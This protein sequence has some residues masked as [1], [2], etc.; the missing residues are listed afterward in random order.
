MTKEEAKIQVARLVEKYKKSEKAGLLKG[1]TEEETKK[2][3]ILPLFE[4][5]GW[6]VYDKQEVSAEEHI[7][8]SGQV[9]YGFYLN[10]RPA[11]YLEA[12]KI[13][14]DLNRPEFANQAVRYSWNKNVPWAILAD[15]EG[16]KVLNAQV[17]ERSLSDKVF[18]DISCDKYLD[19]FDQLWLLSK[20][21]F[22]AGK[23][24]EEAEKWGKKLKRIPVNDLLYKDL[25]KCRS[26]LTTAFH[27]WNKNL[28]A[29]LLYDGVQKVLDRIIFIRVLEDRG[30]EPSTLI[31]MIRQWR[32]KPTKESLYE[33]VSN[34]LQEF[35]DRYNS[36]IFSKH[37]S[38][39]W[40]EHSDAVKEVI[41]I[42]Y[43]REGY[44][45][46]DFKA[47]PADVLGNVYEQ[48]L[49]Y[50]LE[51][52]KKRRLFGTDIEVHKDSEKRK[53]HGIY[54]TPSYIVDYIVK[55][56][57]GPVLDRCTSI[58]DL[59]KIKVLDPACGSGSFLVRAFNLIK[60]KYVLDF[61]KNDDFSLKYMILLNNIYGVDL[62]EQAIEIARLNL[63]IN[64]VDSKRKLPS[65]DQNIKV[66]NSLLQGRDE[67]LIKNLGKNYLDKR[68]F[69]WKAEFPEVFRQGGF[70]VIIGNPPYIGEKGH[71]E[72][73]ID[74]RAGELAEF[75]KGKMD[76]FYFFFHLALNI[77]K[78]SGVIG[79]ITTNYY[80]TATGGNMLRQDMKSRS[81]V[82]QIINLGELKIFESALGQHNIITILQ[83]GHDED[84][85]A[86]VCVTTKEGIANESVLHNII[87]GKDQESSCSEIAQKDLYDGEDNY[88]R[89]GGNAKGSNDPTQKILEKMQKETASLGSIC[90]VNQGIVTGADKV[91]RKHL[92]KYTIEAELGQGIY[93][94]SDGEVNNLKLNK[95][96]KEILKPWYKNSDVHRWKTNS[97]TTE[98]LILADKRLLNLEGNTAKN[99][100]GKFKKI[101][102]DST[103]N[104]PYIHRPRD[105][106][107]D[108][109]KIVVPQRS[110]RNT[111]GY[112]EIPWYAASDVYFITQQDK[113]V[114]LKY[115]LALLNSK[116]YYFWLYHRGKRKGKMLEFVQTPLSE[117]PIQKISEN[118][119]NRFI[120]SA[121]R[122][123]DIVNQDNYLGSPEKQRKVQEYE[124]KI[125]E[126]VY[127]LYGLTQEEINI[128]EEA[129]A[130]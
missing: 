41:N 53:E 61:G 44:Y 62:D 78:E 45:E 93:V 23:L 14:V 94:L 111:F 82:R 122:I 92:S 16:I 5:L 77:A 27:A 113:S 76:I 64:A 80:L 42:L 59:Q 86:K 121:D 73:F 15:F 8:S 98:R 67:D 116:L 38:D 31:P 52:S 57:L 20:E 128:V 75:Y 85:Q 96:E 25:N 74:I 46:Y 3:F 125:D 1:Y 70:D 81:I 99:Y 90:N 114:S 55:S 37:H 22:S 49:G 83:K 87:N 97:E 101:L 51:Q 21:L 109:P 6:E 71:K 72:I 110:M 48:Y 104:S 84:A 88:I 36:H 79:F 28:P 126:E 60:D 106:K 120:L 9:D 124:K 39:K 119:Q 29:N 11:F 65:L 24:D 54:Y 91:S 63:L 7:K 43:G 47:M 105:I 35:N 26:I 95:Q 112:N 17:V 102:D 129:V 66:G 12:K 107:F 40:E 103:S 50:K 32:E 68:P 19:N 69:N 4:A 10:G 33:Y 115:I 108:K 117:V 118:E 56:T 13:S 123:L 58:E 2:D 30:I 18:I 130:I 34:N 127:K 100:L 89:L